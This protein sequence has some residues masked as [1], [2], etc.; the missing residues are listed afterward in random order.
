M[1]E[2]AS[3]AAISSPAK[4]FRYEFSDDFKDALRYFGNLHRGEEL[5]DFKEAWNQWRDDNVALFETEQRRLTERGY[6]GS[7][8]QFN[9]KAY[10]ATRYYFSNRGR[11]GRRQKETKPR[12]KYISLGSVILSQID[13]HLSREL[14]TTGF[15]PAIGFKGFCEEYYYEIRREMETICKYKEL[16]ESELEERVKKTYKNRYFLLIKRLETSAGGDG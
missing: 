2:T 5:E 3:S 16:T 15:T 7:S 6:S 14:Y 8:A 13:E 11:D 12:R 4:V 10:S 1:S 9:T